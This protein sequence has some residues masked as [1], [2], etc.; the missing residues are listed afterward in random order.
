[1][2]D[3]QQTRRM[4][5]KTLNL[6]TSSAVLGDASGAI[7]V[8]GEPGY[9]WIRE[10][11][12]SGFSDRKKIKLGPNVSLSMKPG[13]PVTLGYDFDRE[14]CILAVDGKALVA[15]G[16]NPAQLNP[17]DP[18]QQYAKQDRLITARCFPDGGMFVRTT[19]WWFPVGRRW[20]RFGGKRDDLT[21]LVPSTGEHCLA[22]IFVLEDGTSTEVTSSTPKSQLDDLSIA[23]V[24]ECADAATDGSTPSR[25]WR[26]YGG[27]TEVK[28]NDVFIDGRNIINVGMGQT[29]RF[30][31]IVTAA[32][33]ITVTNAD[34]VILVNKAS[35]AA[36]S[37]NMPASPMTGAQY[38]I[39]DKKGDAASNNITLIGTFD[40][41]TNYVINTNNG[42]ATVMWD[43]TEWSVIAT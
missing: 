9:V 11:Q 19:G 34:D 16:G 30:P 4:V 35:G 6:D 8:L 22:A 3:L 23:D 14:R 39:K 15:S 5:R 36:T 41:A 21:S 1:M 20:V 26:L 18:S 29:R 25:F 33:A 31:R 24:Q 28:D 43:G 17:L 13:T 10:R 40:G 37:V 27:Q 2:G 38:V 7:H 12:A 32:G 42:K